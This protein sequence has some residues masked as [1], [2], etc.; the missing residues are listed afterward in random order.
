MV[1]H[2]R[3]DGRQYRQRPVYTLQR[4]VHGVHYYVVID[5]PDE[6]LKKTSIGNGPFMSI[7]S[8]RLIPAKF[9]LRF[10]LIKT[11]NDFF[12]K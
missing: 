9:R 11:K 6:W 8:Y 7:H 4:G 5:D 3:N 1:K 2:D 10:I 12:A